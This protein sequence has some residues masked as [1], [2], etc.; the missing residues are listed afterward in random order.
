[1][2]RSFSF[3]C[4]DESAASDMGRDVTIGRCNGCSSPLATGLGMK[5]ERGAD[6]L[7]TESGDT[8]SDKRQRKDVCV[9]CHQDLRQNDVGNKVFHPKDPPERFSVIPVIEESILSCETVKCRGR[10][11][12]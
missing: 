10:F 2:V 12:F 3:I 4:Q 11:M 7:V 9:L 6:G 5:R 8:A 1:M